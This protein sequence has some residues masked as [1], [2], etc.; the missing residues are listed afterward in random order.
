MTYEEALTEW[1]K[2]VVLERDQE[3]EA[4]EAA[5]V[6]LIAAGLL[7]LVTRSQ[8][9]QTQETVRAEVKA[10]LLHMVSMA[11][12]LKSTEREDYRFHEG[13]ECCAKTVAHRAGIE[14][15]DK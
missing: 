3:P 14:L 12:D 11:S 5:R 7:E 4:L 8:M 13:V 2:A 6:I 15:E 1:H 10:A 9:H